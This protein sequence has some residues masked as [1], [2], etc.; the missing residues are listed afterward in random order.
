VKFE[1]DKYLDLGEDFYSYSTPL[2]LNKPYLIDYNQSLSKELGLNLSHFEWLE[3]LNG[4]IN[5]KNSTSYSMPYSGHQF[6]FFVPQLGDGRVI[7][8]GVKNG[9]RLQL[10]GSGITKYSRGLDGKATLK[11]SL[12]EY[13]VSEYM[14]SLGVGTVRG[15]AI[16]GAKHQV[17]REDWES[18]AIILRASRSW[19]RFGSF[20]Y[21]SNRKKELERLADYLIN[22]NF[23]YLNGINR[24]YSYL[25]FETS[26][27]VAKN[28]AKC[29]A[30]GFT[31]GVLNSDN[32]LLTGD[33][34]DYGTFGFLE[35]YN[36]N[37]NPNSS[38]K[39]KR[40]SFNRQPEIAK[41]NIRRLGEAIEPL[42]NQKDIEKS[43][44]I[45][46][47]SYKKEFLKTVK[48]RMGI[49]G[50]NPID[51][52]LIKSFFNLLEKYN[53]DYNST[54]LTLA[55]NSLEFN[56]FEGKKW[57]NLYRDRVKD[58]HLSESERRNRMSNMNPRYII[59]ENILDALLTEIEKGDTYLIN[60]IFKIAKNPF[61]KKPHY[62]NFIK[63]LY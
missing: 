44:I 8:I 51:K 32:M 6:G 33:I 46:D 4:E 23:N 38:D 18:S 5:F 3:F 52:T 43:L 16:L 37:F 34:I 20:E 61:K 49:Y 55:N 63:R 1:D 2:P 7:N 17:F 39:R 50:D 13:I 24:K 58:N 36:P 15:V 10:K 19:I 12:K 56:S 21:F 42:I 30:F 35:R 47:N 22:E 62:E 48:A 53:L 60:L 9:Y 27:R 28:I 31:H 54:Y 45:F 41:W 57:L 40:Y 14:N 29:M 11:E 26:K 59:K 25:L